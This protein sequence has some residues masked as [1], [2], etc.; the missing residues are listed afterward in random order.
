MVNNWI[1]II[2]DCLFPPT[3]LLCGAPGIQ[4]K[5]LCQACHDSMPKNDY[6]CFRCGESVET[7]HESS[8]LCGK[9]LKQPPA[10]DITHAPYLYQGAIRHLIYNLKFR[11]RFEN[12]RLLGA[13]LA[14]Y[15]QASVELPELIIP[16]PLHPSRYRE[17]GFNQSIEIARTVS[18]NLSIPLDFF[19]CRRTRNTSHQTDLPAKQRIKNMRNAFSLRKPVPATHIAI[20]DDVMTTGSTVNELAKILSHPKI[21]KIEVWC[22]ARA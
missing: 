21:A 3:C 7:L 12:A 11:A 22:C 18:T 8:Y 20:L 17:R 14:D 5:D 1:D 13:L 9:C 2:Q 10:F 15:L 6:C 16:V 19:S 4:T